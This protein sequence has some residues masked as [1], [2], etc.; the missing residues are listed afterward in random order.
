MSGFPVP[1]NGNPFSNPFLSMF[2]RWLKVHTYTVIIFSRK[3]VMGS[4]FLGT[5]TRLDFSPHMF[6]SPGSGFQVTG[7]R[8]WRPY[9]THIAIHL[10]G[11]LYLGFTKYYRMQIGNSHSREER[12]E[13]RL[14]HWMVD[15]N[16][17]AV[18]IVGSQCSSC[19]RV[20]ADTSHMTIVFLVHWWSLVDLSVVVVLEQSKLEIVFFSKE[21]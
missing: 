4:G 5:G 17:M 11:L 16:N 9:T 2:L 18:D 20:E 21:W 1:R 12:E 15:P 6:Q 3:F 10:T 13:V 14:A 7:A 8:T 19:Q